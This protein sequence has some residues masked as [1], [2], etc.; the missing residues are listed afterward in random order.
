MFANEGDVTCS[1]VYCKV[2]PKEK[3]IVDSRMERRR[4]AEV[5]KELLKEEDE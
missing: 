5:M 2:T 4:Q 3:V 1:H